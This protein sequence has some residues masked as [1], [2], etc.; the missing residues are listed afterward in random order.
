MSYISFSFVFS[1]YFGTSIYGNKDVHI[2]TYIHTYIHINRKKQGATV[3]WYIQRPHRSSPLANNVE[4]IDRKQVWASP[5]I[6]P[7]SASCSGGAGPRLTRNFLPGQRQSA[8]QTASQSVQQFVT[9]NG[10]DQ[11]TDRRTYRRSY[12]GNSYTLHRQK[13]EAYYS[14]AIKVNS[15][16][17]SITERRVLELI[18]VLGSQP[19]GDVSHKPGVGLQLLSARPTV[20]P[21]TLKRAATNF[22]GW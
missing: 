12:N 19:A 7:K 5:S 18:P 2:H 4:N 21:A 11:Q 17:Y 1:S 22:A 3:G 10:R 6:T 15:S 14:L 13:R 8:C 20:T 9:A 16:P